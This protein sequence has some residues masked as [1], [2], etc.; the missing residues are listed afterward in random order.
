MTTDAKNV[1]CEIFEKYCISKN[2]I[3]FID[4]SMYSRVKA[5]AIVDELQSNGYIT[6]EDAMGWTH[7][8]IFVEDALIEY[9]NL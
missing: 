8:R 1:M 5:A 7:Y 9:Y 2:R 3:L 6:K 4:L